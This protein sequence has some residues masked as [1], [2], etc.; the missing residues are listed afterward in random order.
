MHLR[1][2]QAADGTLA[3]E[4]SSPRLAETEHRWL[5]PLV[6]ETQASSAESRAGD[7]VRVR[8][9]GE[10]HLAFYMLILSVPCPLDSAKKIGTVNNEDSINI[11]NHIFDRLAYD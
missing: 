7:A 3:V 11:L 9:H 2:F 1:V 4:V 8:F 10:I 6:P 5:V